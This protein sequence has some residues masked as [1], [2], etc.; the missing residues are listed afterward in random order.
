MGP[1]TFKAD[2]LASYKSAGY[3]QF[4]GRTLNELGM[5][6]VN[7]A[8]WTDALTI[9]ETLVELFP[10]APQAYDSLAYAHFR[11]GDVEQA[12][13]IFSTAVELKPTFIS[14]YASNNYGCLDK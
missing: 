9:F 12:C 7:D 6:L 8:K 13:E 4:V 11:S 3:N 10:E 14:D 5:S 2:F 1:E